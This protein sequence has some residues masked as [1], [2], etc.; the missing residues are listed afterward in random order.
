MENITHRDDATAIRNLLAQVREAFNAGDI[1]KAIHLHTE[2]VIL[3]ESNMPAIS[4]KQ[5]LKEMFTTFFEKRKQ[6]RITATLDF[7][8]LELEVIC[9]RAFTRGKVTLETKKD[10]I[11]SMM[12][13]KFLC[14]LQ[15]QEDGTWLRSH[16]VSNSDSPHDV[17]MD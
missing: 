3:M 13:G 1:E 12:T 15:K 8:I 14:I 5:A 4:G 16:I 6:E 11:A 17:K 2:N 10:G 9:N 7:E